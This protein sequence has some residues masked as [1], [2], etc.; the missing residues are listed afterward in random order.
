MKKKNYQRILRSLR[1][2]LVFFLLAG[3]IVTCCMLLF[4]DVLSS[5]MGVRFTEENIG[6]AAQLT[7]GNVVLLTLLFTVIDALRRKVTVDRPVK[8]ITRAAE[9]IMQ[10]DFS[11]RVPAMGGFGTDDTFHQIIAC[12]N[13][14]AEE[15]SGIETLRT[16]FVAD[17]SHEIKTP[18]A[19]IQNYA[20]L[21]AQGELPEEERK[22]YAKAVM[23]AVRRLTD[24][25]TNILRLSKLENQ[26][27][28]PQFEAYDLGEQLCACL[29]EFEDMWEKKGLEIQSDIT[30]GVLVRSD[31]EMMRLV[32]N[33]LFSNAVKFT[34]KGGR[35]VLSLREEG[36]MAVVVVQDTGCGISQEV[37]RHIFDKFYQG[38]TSHASQGNGLGLALVKRVIDITGAGISV[39]SEVGRGSSFTV[40]IRK[41]EKE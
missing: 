4:L 3:F 7:F 9:K 17:V 37:G 41:Y 8:Q 32:W 35:V 2:Y 21:L 29:L 10:G 31:R 26:Q 13:K 27:I 33:N 23:D 34:E 19:V 24:L 16:D 22:E 25:I 11:V 1:N 18:L 5:D 6:V 28:F 14:M 40:R 36:E 38:D 15:L 39:Q 30:D 20:T 12:F